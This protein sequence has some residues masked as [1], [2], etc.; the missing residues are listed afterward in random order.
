MKEIE[1]KIHDED[2][3]ES[4]SLTEKTDSK[5]KMMSLGLSEENDLNLNSRRKKNENKESV[6]VSNHTKKESGSSLLY[7]DFK[8]ENKNQEEKNQKYSE[9]EVNYKIIP[10]PKNSQS[11]NE[12]LILNHDEEFFDRNNFFENKSKSKIEIQLEKIKDSEDVEISNNSIN[13]SKEFLTKENVMNLLNLDDYQ[14]SNHNTQ[15]IRNSLKLDLKYNEENTQKTKFSLIKQIKLSLNRKNSEKKSIKKIVKKSSIS[16]ISLEENKNKNINKFDRSDNLDQILNEIGQKNAMQKFFESNKKKKSIQIDKETEINEQKTSINSEENLDISKN[17][18]SEQ[19]SK[20]NLKKSEDYPNNNK[21]SLT[22]FELNFNPNPNTVESDILVSCQVF[23]SDKKS[24]EID[25][26]KKKKTLSFDQNQD[27]LFIPESEEMIEKV[28][29]NRYI[30]QVAE[31]NSI[32][33]EILNEQPFDTFT[34]IASENLGKYLTKAESTTQLQSRIVQINNLFPSKDEAL[35]NFQNDFLDE[36]YDIENQID[37]EL[38]LIQSNRSSF[39]EQ[40][41]VVHQE[42]DTKIRSV[43]SFI[44]ENEII[45]TE[46]E[47]KSQVFHSKNY[48]HLIDKNDLDQ[49]DD[50]SNF[51]SSE[52][53]NR[54][55]SKTNRN[56]LRL[57]FSSLSLSKN[58]DKKSATSILSGKTR[59]TKSKSLSV[60]TLFKRPSKLSNNSVYDSIHFYCLLKYRI[61]HLLKIK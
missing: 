47:K 45:L 6:N 23:Y 15:E 46:F 38:E 54:M 50:Q 31:S 30:Y 49:S 57:S 36:S 32:D 7:T 52:I 1:T 26:L 40:E 21:E 58:F 56:S 61:K 37:Q 20:E 43:S 48:Y 10:N 19:I 39:E 16:Q 9:K 27:F 3:K 29:R 17:L 5:V 8:N 51:R 11:L 22:N 4:L 34:E 18:L 35:F 24:K 44:S 25:D 12:S 42:I 33:F 2:I 28:K 55:K 14:Q 59:I 41:K 60:D 13:F 53:I